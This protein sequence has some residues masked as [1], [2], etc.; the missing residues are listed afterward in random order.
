LLAKQNQNNRFGNHRK[1]E[2]HRNINK[3]YVS[4]GET[5]T[6]PQLYL[7]ICRCRKNWKSH[8]RQDMG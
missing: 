2:H 5:H 8:T 3:H 4:Y 7:V 6:T 1:P